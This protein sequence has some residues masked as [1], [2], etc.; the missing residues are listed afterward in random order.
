MANRLLCRCDFYSRYNA[1]IV[2]VSA[3]AY[4]YNWDYLDAKINIISSSSG[5][6]SD[7]TVKDEGS[8]LST[9]AVYF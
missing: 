3:S 4:L 5:G 9:A 1:S 2:P 8:N 6:G 7:I